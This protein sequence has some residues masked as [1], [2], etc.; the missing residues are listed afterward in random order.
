MKKAICKIITYLI[1]LF[2]ILILIDLASFTDKGNAILSRVFMS[3]NYRHVGSLMI[4][5]AIRTA[6]T[7][8]DHT[9]VILGDSMCNQVFSDF[10]D[11]NDDYLILGTNMAVTVDGQYIMARRFLETHPD[12]ADVYLI[13]LPVSFAGRY[14]SAQSYSYLVEPFGREELLTYLSDDTIS[15]MK[16]HYG[17]IFLNRNVIRF[18]DGSSINNKLYLYYLQ[19][20]KAV[21]DTDEIISDEAL[22]YLT[23]LKKI[24]DEKGVALHL[25]PPPVCDSKDNADRIDRLRKATADTEVSVLF[26][27][28]F[29]CITLYP[30]YMFLD[31]HHFNSDYSDIEMNSN[32]IDDLQNKS[33]ELQGLC[34]RWNNRE[35]LP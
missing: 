2:L 19:K 30:E 21:P 34:I 6:Q 26:D 17:S 27:K 8:S 24:C 20:N 31:G 5:P 35:E 25:L 22:Y 12:A 3:E 28:Y 11:Q 32:R 33:H 4:S 1:P 16:E 10:K 9:K 29:D 14:D 18:L 7:Q 23:D 15:G 13:L